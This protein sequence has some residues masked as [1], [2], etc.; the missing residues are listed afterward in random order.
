MKTKT[1][2]TKIS[3]EEKY[4]QLGLNISHYRKVKKLSQGELAERV[5]ISRGHLS[6]IESPNMS[7]SFSIAT[8]FDIAEALDIEPKLLFEFKEI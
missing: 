1:F 5:H 8:L 6:H 4:R 7:S 3:N 2:E